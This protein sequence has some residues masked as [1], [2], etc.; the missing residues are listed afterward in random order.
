VSPTFQ[1]LVAPGGVW[2]VVPEISVA[3]PQNCGAMTRGA[4]ARVRVGR[5]GGLTV[6]PLMPHFTVPLSPAV[7]CNPLSRGESDGPA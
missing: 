2:F 4:I 1:L 5:V 6:D 7:Q 3:E